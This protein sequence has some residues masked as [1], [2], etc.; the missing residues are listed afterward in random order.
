MAKFSLILLALCLAVVSCV[1]VQPETADFIGNPYLP[2]WEH[3]PDGE[4]RVFEDPDNPGHY[5][6]YVTGSHDTRVESYCGQDDRQWS[7]PVEDL[8]AWRDEGPVF[9]YT[10]NGN[11]STVYAPDLVEVT[12]RDDGS[13]KYYLYPH[14]LMHTPMVCVGDR[15]DGPFTVLNVQ[16]GQLAPGSIMGF[17]PGVLVEQIDDPA[18]PDYAIGFRAYGAWGIQR[19]SA[20]ELDQNTMYTPRYGSPDYPF[21]VPSMIMSYLANLPKGQAVAEEMKQLTQELGLQIVS[22][23]VPDK[24]QIVPML[25]YANTV[26]CHFV[27]LS[28]ELLR[29]EAD[30]HRWAK[31]LNEYGKACKE[32]GCMMIYHNHTQEFLSCGDKRIIDILLDETDPEL[33][34]FELDAGWCAAAGFD[35]VEHVQRYSGRIKLVHVKE[36]SEVIGVQPPIDFD[37]V[38]WVDGKPVF[39]PEIQ[40]MLAHAREINCPACEGLVDWKKLKEAADANGCQAYIVERVGGHCNRKRRRAGTMSLRAGVNLRLVCRVAPKELLPYVETNDAIALR[41]H[42]LEHNVHGVV[43][44]RYLAQTVS[45]LVGAIAVVVL[46]VGKLPTTGRRDLETLVSHELNAAALWHPQ[47]VLEPELAASDGF[48]AVLDALDG[49]RRADHLD[50]EGVGLTL[51]LQANARRTQALGLE[52]QPIVATTDLCRLRPNDPGVARLDIRGLLDGELLAGHRK[53]IRALRVGQDNGA[54]R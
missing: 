51:V 9:T 47:P 10:Q 35:P 18:D 13:H 36:S 24:N 4:P 40:A 45:L 33:V 17:D 34:G 50:G 29:D 37:K 26:G 43:G 38:E 32:A 41:L 23:H 21:W 8:T 6:I 27:G 49:V 25:P 46:D 28:S 2:L 11:M 52:E 44:R 53:E 5:R 12:R 19:A 3:V 31:E 30:A 20:T 48:G 16:D 1:R 39:T 7:A 22:M 15:P 42:V 54:L 14:A